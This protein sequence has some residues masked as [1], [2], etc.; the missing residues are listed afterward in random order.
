MY[1]LKFEEENTIKDRQL[2]KTLLPSI[3][4]PD[5]KDIIAKT[6]YI[7]G[8]IIAII[9]GVSGEA[10]FEMIYALFFGGYTVFLVNKKYPYTEH[11]T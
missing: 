8:T 7:I 11:E 6:I 9:I 1:F 4:T 5:E 3:A 2:L 10:W